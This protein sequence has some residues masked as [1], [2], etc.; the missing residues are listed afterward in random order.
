MT[1]NED[2]ASWV[3]GRTDWQKDAVAG[4]CRNE[5]LSAEDIAAIADQLIAGT[6]PTAANISAAD[7]PGSTAAGDPISLVQVAGVAGVNALIEGQTLSFGAAGMTVI[8][9][10][11]A[12]GKSGYARL[13]REAV[14]ARVKA[15]HLLGDVF[16]EGETAQAAKLGYLVGTKPVTWSLGD[17]QST[18]LSRIRY[19]DEDCGDAYVTAASEV[20]YRPSA[21]TILDQLS[22]ACEAVA[23]ELTRHLGTNQAGRPQLPCSIPRQQVRPSCLV[24]RRQPARKRSRR[25]R[26]WLAT[27]TRSLRSSSRRKHASRAATPT[28]RRRDFPRYRATG[29]RWMHTPRRSRQ[30][31]VQIRCGP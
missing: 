5:T 2:L 19:Y 18:D 27:T 25:L 1:L 28:R 9:G 20:N 7:I 6:Y 8:F 3:A 31:S 22:D 12:S 13:I 4:F 17:S 26:R 16:A 10:N 11:N 21:L 29:Q 23:A 24:S 30:F 15:E 14:T